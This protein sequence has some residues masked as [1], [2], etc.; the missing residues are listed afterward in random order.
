MMVRA[1][2]IAVWILIILTLVSGVILGVKSID[3]VSQH[4][5][6]SVVERIWEG[7]KR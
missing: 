2:I 3:Y 5:L 7:E 4:G 6:K 1:V